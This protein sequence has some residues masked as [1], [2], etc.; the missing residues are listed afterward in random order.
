MISKLND[1]QAASCSETL[2][3]SSLRPGT[4]QQLLGVMLSG[5]RGVPVQVQTCRDRE[6]LGTRVQSFLP[7][8]SSMQ[9]LPS[10]SQWA[11]AGLLSSSSLCSRPDSCLLQPLA[12]SLAPWVLPVSAPLGYSAGPACSAASQIITNGTD[13]SEKTFAFNL[14]NVL[15]CQHVTDLCQFGT[16]LYR[17]S[18]CVNVV[19]RI[20]ELMDD[21][22]QQSLFT[23]ESK[24]RYNVALL[25]MPGQCV[26]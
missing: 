20:P 18:I 23:I 25:S 9:S 24:R 5:P 2:R 17:S 13:L 26:T 21:G 6:Q 3:E 4:D 22:E 8:A 11:E 12:A 10:G 1:Q 19:N 14:V 7:S 16:R 15:R